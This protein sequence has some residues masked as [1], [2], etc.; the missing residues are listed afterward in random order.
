MLSTWDRRR[1]GDT[2]VANREGRESGI[3]QAG[4][5]QLASSRRQQRLSLYPAN[6]LINRRETND[7]GMQQ[8]PESSPTAGLPP[9][10]L[11]ADGRRIQSSKKEVLYTPPLIGV[12]HFIYRLPLSEDLEICEP[13]CPP[14][15]LLLPPEVQRPKLSLH[16]LLNRL[17][18]LLPS[19]ETVLEGM[20]IGQHGMPIPPPAI[21][22]VIRRPTVVPPESGTF[23]L[24]PTTLIAKSNSQE[25]CDSQTVEERE[26]KANFTIVAPYAPTSTDLKQPL[27]S[28]LLDGKSISAREKYGG[29]AKR[30]TSAAASKAK[31]HEV[32]EE[33]SDQSEAPKRI[34][35]NEYPENTVELK[36]TNN[37]TALADLVLSFLGDV[38]EENVCVE[39]KALRLL[40][41]ECQSVRLWVFPRTIKR[42]EDALVCCILNNPEPFLLPFG[43]DGVMPELELDTKTIF[44]EKVLLHRIESK[45]IV[46][47]NNTLLP[48]VW[49]I[50]GAEMLGEDFALA[51]VCGIVPPMEESAVTVVFRAS[52]PYKANFK[53]NLRL[54]VYDKENIAGLVH[55]E[56]I[57][58]QAEAYDVL[59]DI[60]FSKGK[61]ASVGLAIFRSFTEAAFDGEN[62]IHCEVYDPHYKQGPELIASIPIPITANVNFSKFSILPSKEMNFGAMLLHSRKSRQFGIENCGNFDFKFTIM[63]MTKAQELRA[64]RE[65]IKGR[66][67]T[68]RHKVIDILSTK[69]GGNR[70]QLGPFSVSPTSGV[71][72]AGAYLAIT[73][74][75][76][77][78][79]LGYFQEELCLDISDRDASEGPL[80]LSYMLLAES[81]FPYINVDDIA[82]IFEEHRIC[83]NYDMLQAI[84][85]TEATMI[86]AA[87]EDIKEG[88]QIASSTF[89]VNLYVSVIFCPPS[90]QAYSG[91][92]EAAIEL[93][94]TTQQT[95]NSN[96]Q[97]S[98]PAD[99]QRT[100]V[101]ELCGQ[102]HLPRISILRPSLRN[103][104]GELTCVFP[105][106]RA[107]EIIKREI[108]FLND[109]TFVSTV[110]TVVLRSSHMP[111]L[112][113]MNPILSLYSC[114][115]L[116][117]K[118]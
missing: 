99:V 115:R 49:K 8:I 19:Q 23:K 87:G 75:C 36:L 82:D 84:K 29:G 11:C 103:L 9:V 41:N 80:G 48:A 37:S 100:L 66:R 78:D 104:R 50:L 101:F 102:G 107:R 38:K 6:K 109:G 10:Y 70:L 22:S 34:K 39:P 7:S 114:V 57:V 93:G 92:F 4:T 46:L 1:E 47:R 74:D 25:T 117:S 59:L 96:A 14:P 111:Y 61:I 17:Q 5:N 31:L 26:A 52:R 44:F 118:V 69:D 30:R 110:S 35:A 32:V 56:T 79:A 89:T 3:S 97:K 33:L 83:K 27:H 95:D 16:D 13:I 51:S 68:S 2:S 76:A 94:Q 40:P 88:Q 105:R 24:S 55:V 106:I 54:E 12:P 60:I 77:V 81:C 28:S 112:G 20:G 18:P 72:P 67:R 43:C 63:P 71:V 15:S 65:G 85:D 45:K 53:K 98:E 90:I 116:R 86:F 73:V 91:L 42:F 64:L 58:V 21:F 62:L 108:V 113:W